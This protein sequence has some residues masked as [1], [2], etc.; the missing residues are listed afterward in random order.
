MRRLAAHQTA[1]KPPKATIR[2]MIGGAPERMRTA[3]AL[4]R[5]V[6]CEDGTQRP[7]VKGAALDQPAWYVEAIAAWSGALAE[8]RNKRMERQRKRGGRR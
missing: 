8:A 2:A 1:E 7:I 4:A 6:M 3:L 5:L